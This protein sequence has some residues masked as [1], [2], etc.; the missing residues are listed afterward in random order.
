MLPFVF[1]YLCFLQFDPNRTL[2]EQSSELPYDP[3]WEFPRD[4]L[5]FV[6]MIGSGAFG[7]VWLAEAEG[8]LTLDPRDKTSIAAKRRSKIKRSQR[9][10]HLYTKERKKAQLPESSGEKTFVAVKTLKGSYTDKRSFFSWFLVF[11][12]NISIATIAIYTRVVCVVSFC[13]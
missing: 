8:I 6:K 10:T 1:K 9:Y 3:D 2:F 4:R 11:Q 13:N 5:N 7:E 12:H